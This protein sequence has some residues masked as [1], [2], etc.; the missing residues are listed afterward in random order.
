M[1]II[2]III[3]III[4]IIAFICMNEKYIKISII[5]YVVAIV[6]LIGSEISYYNDEPEMNQHE[7]VQI[8]INL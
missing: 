6:C 5:L 1:W 4:F 8:I 2:L 3:A 7:D